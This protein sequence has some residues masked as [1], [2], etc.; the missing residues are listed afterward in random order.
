MFT[1][2]WLGDPSPTYDS[3]PQH[4]LARDEYDEMV[5]IRNNG[6]SLI[7]A[8]DLEGALE[9]FNGLGARN[10]DIHH[11]GRSAGT[12]SDQVYEHKVITPHFPF[13]T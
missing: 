2:A 3:V 13:S 7:A 9:Y 10:D 4:W 5:R 1:S 8:V 6:H 11:V 12:L